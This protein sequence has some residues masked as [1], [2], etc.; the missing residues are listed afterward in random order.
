MT[1]FRV[2]T[3]MQFEKEKHM[4]FALHLLVVMNYANMPFLLLLLI[5]EI[6]FLFL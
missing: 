1:D 5:L 2:H 6:L 4:D 3:F